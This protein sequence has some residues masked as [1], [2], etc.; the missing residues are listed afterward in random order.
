ME[1]HFENFYPPG[2]LWMLACFLL[3]LQECGRRGLQRSSAGE[4]RY[5]ALGV[6]IFIDSLTNF[7]T[8]LIIIT[9]VIISSIPVAITNACTKYMYCPALS[10]EYLEGKWRKRGREDEEETFCTISE[11]L[12]A[13]IALSTELPPIG[14]KKFSIHCSPLPS[15]SAVFTYSPSTSSQQYLPH[16]K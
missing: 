3:L 6:R 4:V 2:F 1:T 13:L 11:K 5:G 10:L 12:L 7:V 16:E 14:L 8:A 15:L 9:S